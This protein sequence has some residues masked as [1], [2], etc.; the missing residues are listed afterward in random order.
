MEC[1]CARDERDRAGCARDRQCRVHHGVCQQ[2]E[3]LE[4]PASRAGGRGLS[5][6]GDS[7]EDTPSS[8]SKTKCGFLDT[9]GALIAEADVRKAILVAAANDAAHGLGS[10]RVRSLRRTTTPGPHLVRYSLAGIDSSLDPDTLG[11]PPRRCSE[12]AFTNVG[13]SLTLNTAI[14]TYNLA[15][16]K[17]DKAGEDVL[18]ASKRQDAAQA[19]RDKAKGDLESAKTD[20]ELAEKD[21]ADAIKAGTGEAAARSALT[22][23]KAKLK[24]V[25]GAADVRPK[26]LCANGKERPVHNHG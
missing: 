16:D 17:S 5:G 26:K 15:D 20:E 8:S 7:T 25:T 3:G 10:K 6:G 23:A 14:T 4:R 21:L 19:V 24:T 22:S 1:R 9:N 13:N 2:S 12:G 18:A 11:K